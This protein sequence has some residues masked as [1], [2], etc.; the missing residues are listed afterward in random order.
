MFSTL[1]DFPT[2]WSRLREEDLYWRIGF[3]GLSAAGIVHALFIPL[4]WYLGIPWLAAFNLLSV[5]AYWY[6]IF[7]LGL[8]AIE[9]GDDRLIGWIV[10]CELIGHN[11]LATYF[12]GTGAGFQLYIY[13]LALLPFFI[14]SYSKEVYLVRILF[15]IFIAIVIDRAPLFH[16]AKVPL[17]PLTIH[18]LHT[19]N[20]TIF[21]GVLSLLSYLY[22]VHTKKSQE[23]LI[24]VTYRDPLTGLYNRRFVS[25][26]AERIFDGRSETGS[27]VG[28]LLADLDRFKALNDTYGH[29]C[30]DRALEQVARILSDNIFKGTVARWGGEEFLIFFESIDRKRLWETA[31]QIRRIIRDE[32]LRCGETS[33]RITVTIGGTLRR[34]REEFSQLFKRADLALYEGKE[35]GRDRIV[36][37]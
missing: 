37:R 1:T 12:L 10:Y 7:G 8:P 28:I 14:F 6:S 20:L 15:V 17:D 26:L 2:L 33:I 29:D 34:E 27:G 3:Y 13:V 18:D 23:E 32:E 22:T 30:G 36:I 31:E 21:L 24:D 9:S 5:F 19:F 4:F 25:K 35:R 16:E 11:L